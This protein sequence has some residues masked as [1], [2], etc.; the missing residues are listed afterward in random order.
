MRGP[1][2]RQ[3][4]YDRR[5]PAPHGYVVPRY[6][7]GPAY[8]VAPY[9]HRFERPYYAFRP[10]THIGFGLWLGFGV[11]YPRAYIASYPPPVYGYYGGRFGVVPGARIYGGVSFDIMPAYAP[12]YVDGN[13]IGVASDFGPYGM[14]LTLVPGPHRVM[15]SVGGYRPITWNVT[16]LAGQVIPFHGTMVAY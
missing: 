15:I 6:D 9:R 16:V 7:R 3:Q 5:V 4:Y 14:P 2:P 1:A 13:Y 10:R 12:I 11:P 8:R